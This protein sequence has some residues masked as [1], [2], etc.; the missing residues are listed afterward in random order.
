M[1]GLRGGAAGG[2]RAWQDKSLGFDGAGFW[3]FG[4]AGI[5]RTTNLV[6]QANV[7]LHFCGVKADSAP[8]EQA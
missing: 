5:P 8:Y 1:E 4:G 7:D 2:P 3:P 6:D